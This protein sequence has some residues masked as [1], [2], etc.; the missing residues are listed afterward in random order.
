MGASSATPH[1]RWSEASFDRAR[2]AAARVMRN[3]MADRDAVTLG[4]RDERLQLKRELS[5]H[6]SDRDR[7]WQHRL[8]GNPL[9]R[10]L[11]GEHERNLAAKQVHSHWHRK[12]ARWR[13]LHKCPFPPFERDKMLELRA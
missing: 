1:E 8:E 11:V 9:T 12:M 13:A 7:R 5:D 10:D 4:L 6:I 3:Q 2:E